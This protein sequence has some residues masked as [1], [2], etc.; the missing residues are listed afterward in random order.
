M[1]KIFT[2]EEIAAIAPNY[3]GKAEH[4]KP[5]FKSQPKSSESAR[6]KPTGRPKRG[7][8]G[9]GL[10]PPSSVAENN[11]NPTPQKNHNMWE[12][13]IFGLDVRVV[14]ITPTQEFD[15]N[16]SKAI[17][18]S[19]EIYANLSPDDPH[20]DKKLAK[21][22]L[23]YYTA[24]LA[25]M[26]LLDIKQ[27]QTK[28]ALTIEE[29]A[30]IA[31]VADVELNVP[32]PLMTY[33]TALGANTDEM[34]KTT[35]LRVPQLPTTVV[36]GFGGYHAANINADTHNLFEEVPC[37]GIMADAVMAQSAV[38]P[39]AVNYR[40]ATPNGATIGT[41]LVGWTT[42]PA[43]PRPEI[44]RRL[45]GQGITDTEFPEFVPNTRFN[46]KYLLSISDE[47]SKITTFRLDK[48]K[49]QTLSRLG[50]PAVVITTRPKLPE[51]S[52]DWKSRSVEASSA[53]ES[54]T[55]QMGLAL[56]CGFQLYKEDGP[57]A[58]NDEKSKNWSSVIPDPATAADA[59]WTM[60]DPWKNNRNGRR[61]LPAGVGTE[62]FRTL[63]ERQDCLMTNIVRRMI[64]TTR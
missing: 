34:G 16:L 48:F 26:R 6:P 58:N 3:R 33:L 32:Q 59:R 8:S 41:G 46:L 5:N 43:P 49:V 22:E 21:L 38:A 57:G 29:K 15:A 45:W 27:K 19:D 61:N 42:R 11:A 30:I 47:L 52:F 10:A 39:A 55:S 7:P 1:A 2:K 9:P 63:I 53:A 28:T 23:R 54:P 35:H 31:S 64:S 13:A 17:N 62:R 12:E 37:L 14:E 25:W 24:A 40:V 44:T 18:V 51:E 60:P 36:A 56:M 20:L 4:F 50:A